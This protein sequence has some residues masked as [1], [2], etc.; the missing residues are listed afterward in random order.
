MRAIQRVA[1][2]SSSA[3]RT[4]VPYVLLI[5]TCDEESS[6][7]CSHSLCRYYFPFIQRVYS[8]VVPVDVCE[9][10]EQMEAQNQRLA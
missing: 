10:T 7:I 1:I 8:D 5:S 2:G 4:P 9:M 6:V 3:G